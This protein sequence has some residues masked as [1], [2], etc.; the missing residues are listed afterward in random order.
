M[1]VIPLFANSTPMGQHNAVTL[2]NM[3]TIN[4]PPEKG[5]HESDAP[6]SQSQCKNRE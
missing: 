6:S 1:K 2:R 4:D 5:N 3:A